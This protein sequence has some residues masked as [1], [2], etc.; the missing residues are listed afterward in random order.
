MKASAVGIAVLFLV[1]GLFPCL[2]HTPNTTKTT[3]SISQDTNTVANT[4][5]ITCYTIGLQGAKSIQK[6]TISTAE[7]EWMITTL[8]SLKHETVRNPQSEQTQDLQKELLM[9]SDEHHLLPAGVSATS[10]QAQLKTT[11]TFPSKHLLSSPLIQG[12]ASEWFC[13]FATFGD[14]STLPIII[15]PRFIPFLVTPIPRAFVAWSTPDGITSVGGLISHTGFIAAGTQKGIALGFWGIGFSIFLPPIMSYGIFGYAMFTRVTAEQF[16]FYPP[17]NP[18]EITQTDPVDGQQMVPMSTSELRFS[19]QDADG[20]LMTYSVTTEPDIGSGSGGLKPDGTYSIP[21]SG[22]ESFT[23]YT[24]H[25]QVTDGEDTI[26][27]TLT[28]TTEPV[29]PVISNPIPADGERDV[30]MD[31]PHLQ[32]TLHDYQGDMMEYTVTTSPDIGSAHATGVHDATYTVPISGLTYGATYRWYVNVTDGSH[33]TRKMFRFETGY[34][35][36]FNPF[37]YGWQYRKQIIIDHTKVVGTLTN[38]PVLVSIVDVD[39][40]QKAQDDGDD[41][42]FM[43]AP[44]VA[45]RLNHEI[46][47]FDANSGKLVAWVNVTALSSINDTMFYLYYG[48]PSCITQQHPE[49]TWDSDYVAVWHFG[50]TSGNNVA[51]STKNHFNGTANA[52]TTITN[53]YVG[54]ARYF[55]GTNGGIHVGTQ[56]EFGGITSYTLEAWAVTKDISSQRRIFDRTQ[57]HDVNPNRILFV[58]LPA[59]A[60][61]YITTNEANSGS[62]PYAFSVDVW[63]HVVGVFTGSGGETAIYKNGVKGT[64]VTTTQPGVTA[65]SFS[66]DIGQTSMVSYLRWYGTL[67]EMRFSKIA[68]T[69]T[70]INT[71]YQNQNDPAGFLN[72]GPEEPGP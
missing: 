36:Q 26:E 45:T 32:F 69:S 58:L 44:G 48:N 5:E 4:A 38:F 31:T 34:P 70:W 29:A 65:G 42:L 17:N 15:L 1:S 50:E 56:P 9:F 61:L 30:P 10:L 66:V 23:Q 41:I 24:W 67:D 25:I 11:P 55:D 35:S 14:G 49:K 6:T 72:V 28:F 18:P 27:K 46:E 71:S 20:D 37:D 63:A 39:L 52:Y 3:A 60:T 7:A 19:I 47:Q 16:E 57:S 40:S 33:W 8:Q 12:K 21:V 22:L 53:G 43:N 2:A 64:P 51:D 13:N 59:S 62:Y 54:N 68:R